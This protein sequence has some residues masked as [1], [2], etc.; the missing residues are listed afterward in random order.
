MLDSVILGAI[1]GLL[2]G[3]WLVILWLG[4]ELTGVA[5]AIRSAMRWRVAPRRQERAWSLSPPL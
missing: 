3:E 4:L 2:A 1:C 5:D